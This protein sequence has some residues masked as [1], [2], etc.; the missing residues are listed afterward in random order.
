MSLSILS[1][2]ILP[3]MHFYIY[4]WQV[5]TK[6]VEEYPEMKLVSAEWLDDCLLRKK[7]LPTE[8]YELC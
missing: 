1:L 2:C 3:V 5:V 8:N 4:F 6:L 7:C